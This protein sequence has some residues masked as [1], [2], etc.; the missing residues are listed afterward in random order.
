MLLSVFLIVA[1]TLAATTHTVYAYMDPGTG[2]MVLQILLA[3]LL[4]SIFMI[5][6]FWH[7][8]TGIL[9]RLLARIKGANPPME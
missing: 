4:G 5:K 8:L 3:T 6:T 7:R 2:S 1:S 9:A